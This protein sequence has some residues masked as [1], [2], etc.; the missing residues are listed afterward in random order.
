MRLPDFKF[1]SPLWEE[2]YSVIGIDEVGRGA[3]A[4]PVGIG[5]VRFSP[6]MTNRDKKKILELGIN[7]SKKLSKRKREYLDAAIKELADA[8]CVVFIDVDVV[9]KIG[10]G[11]ATEKGMVEVAKALSRDY[12]ASYLLVDAFKVPLDIKQKNI[13]HGDCLSVSIAAASIIAKVARDKLMS[14]LSE[15]YPLYGFDKHK[16]YGTALHREN[17]AIF[18]PSDQHRLDFCRKALN[19]F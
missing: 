18:G 16:G 12:L 7:D 19:A 4:G 13:I 11:S 9:N 15:N 14:R 10:V 8:Y 3:L 6:G 2:G 1:E 17:I 5:G